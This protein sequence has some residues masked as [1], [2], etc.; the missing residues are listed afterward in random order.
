MIN[1]DSL[2]ARPGARW[3][4]DRR[5]Y[6]SQDGQVVEAS[7][8]RRHALLVGQGGS[9]PLEQARALGLV[10]EAGE[11]AG[12]EPVPAKRKGGRK[13]AAEGE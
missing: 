4:A 9:I 2:K 5:L 10:A 8:P 11:A 3:T 12:A 6:L 13:P 7:D 1:S